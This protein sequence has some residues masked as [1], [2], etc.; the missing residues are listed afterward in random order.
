MK[1]NLTQWP[2]LVDY[3][4]TL[5]IIF[6]TDN[7]IFVEDRIFKLFVFVLVIIVFFY[8]KKKLDIQV[9]FVSFIVIFIILLQG[10]KWGVNWFTVLSY[11]VL[12]V[13]TSYFFIKIVGFKF[14]IIS[15][16]LIYYSALISLPL[17][18]GQVISSSFTQFLYIIEK[19]FEAISS[20]PVRPSILIYSIAHNTVDQ[21]NMSDFLRNPGMFHE[22]GAFAV[23]LVFAFAVNLIKSQRVIT[24]RNI[25]IVLTIITTFSTAGYLA[26]FATIFFLHNIL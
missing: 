14:L 16:N 18:L 7:P 20:L 2:K 3:F 6:I 17:F 8:R 25:I 11:L 1:L 9:F 13:F 12:M 19:P 26:L 22:P 4:L 24:T 23:F 5:L 10:W 15:S 21:G